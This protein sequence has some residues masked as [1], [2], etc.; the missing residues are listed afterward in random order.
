MVVP[1]LWERTD[2]H[3]LSS[4]VQEAIGTPKPPFYLLQLMVAA[5]FHPSFHPSPRSCG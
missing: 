1:Q 5:S 4:R 2:V 3:S